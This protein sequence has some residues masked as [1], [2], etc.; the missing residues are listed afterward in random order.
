MPFGWG[1]TD[2][3]SLR[4]MK[5]G[6]R[7]DNEIKTPAIPF[8]QYSRVPDAWRAVFDRIKSEGVVNH[9]CGIHAHMKINSRLH[10]FTHDIKLALLNRFKSYP[11]KF[12]LKEYCEPRIADD[13]Y[14][15]VNE[16]S[17]IHI[18]L[19]AF[20][21]TVRWES[22]IRYFNQIKNVMAAA[23]AAH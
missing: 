2:D 5:S 10:I 14:V 1:A 20:N 6:Y 13:H 12:R 22:F 18:E 11:N 15:I 9:S 3:G 19:R 7:Y 8:H 4:Q 17:P 23:C 21:G 16:K